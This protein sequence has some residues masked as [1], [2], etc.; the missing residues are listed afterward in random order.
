MTPG[1]K[2][3]FSLS[4]PQHQL[5]SSPD[6]AQGGPKSWG[7]SNTHCLADGLLLPWQDWRRLCEVGS[8]GSGTPGR[9]RGGVCPRP[10][11]SQRGPDVPF[12]GSPSAQGH[13]SGQHSLP[14]RKCP[15]VSSAPTP[16]LTPWPQLGLGRW[17]K[18][19]T[20]L[21]R[22]GSTFQTP[23]SPLPTCDFFL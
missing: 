18:P 13:L 1:H 22:M 21:P 8:K 3:H 10:L 17:G 20:I 15:L 23:P 4:H 12:L 9:L 14:D 11:G 5:S 2:E 6:P 19:G 7:N 16:S